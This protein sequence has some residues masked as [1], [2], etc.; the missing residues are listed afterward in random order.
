MWNFRVELKELQ[1]E[2]VGSWFPRFLNHRKPSYRWITFVTKA[3]FCSVYLP[4]NFA[5]CKEEFQLRSQTMLHLDTFFSCLHQAETRR[6]SVCPNDS[7][8]WLF[9]SMIGWALLHLSL[10][11]SSAWVKLL[12]LFLSV[13]QMEGQG[14]FVGRI[15]DEISLGRD[16]LSFI[17]YFSCSLSNILAFVS[18]SSV[19]SLWPLINS[20]T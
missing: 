17:F 1:T 12:Q 3:H 20:V 16:M 14:I 7:P 2:L 15:F 10:Q 9:S 4:W 8:A 18:D 11:E 6:F 5:S 13:T 19:P